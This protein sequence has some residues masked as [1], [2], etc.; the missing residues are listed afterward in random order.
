[1]IEG[2]LSKEGTAIAAL[3]F[4]NSIG[5]DPDLMKKA[6]DPFGVL[7]FGELP[8]PKEPAGRNRDRTGCSRGRG[9]PDYGAPREK[10]LPLSAR[11]QAEKIAGEHEFR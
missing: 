11:L 2:S 6:Y 1:M 9:G 7:D 10:P 4:S 8:H 3:P 5:F